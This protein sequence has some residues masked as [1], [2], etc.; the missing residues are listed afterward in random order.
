MRGTPTASRRICW[1]L[2]QW[3]QHRFDLGSNA[4]VE[5]APQ[6]WRWRASGDSRASKHLSP[7]CGDKRTCGWQPPWQYGEAYMVQ[8]G[9]LNTAELQA[10]FGAKYSVGWGD[11]PL[12]CGVWQ[13]VCAW[14]ELVE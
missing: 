4:G 14:M 11:D 9:L 5:K 7:V 13:K 2:A 12:L 10:A 1:G 3:Q 8:T 6:E